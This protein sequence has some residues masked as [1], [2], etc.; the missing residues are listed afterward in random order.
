MKREDLETRLKN[1]EKN[2][3]QLLANFNMLSGGKQEILY[4]LSEI[5]KANEPK[6]E[7]KENLDNAA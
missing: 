2:M 6:K 7:D 1:I 5:D 4:W 3:E